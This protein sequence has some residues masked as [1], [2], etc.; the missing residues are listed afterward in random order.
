MASNNAASARHCG[1]Q[2]N[3][4]ISACTISSL[5]LSAD[6]ATWQQCEGL[7]DTAMHNDLSQSQHHSHITHTL[8]MFD[9]TQLSCNIDLFG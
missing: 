2:D 6:F 4:I 5:N 1:M 3:F 7:C 8:S 9:A